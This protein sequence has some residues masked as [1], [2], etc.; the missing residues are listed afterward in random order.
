MDYKKS[1]ILCVAALAIFAVQAKG[2]FLPT[3]KPAELLPKGEYRCPAVCSAQAPMP[4]AV[5]KQVL[6]EL[7]ALDPTVKA[8]FGKYLD[9]IA[10]AMRNTSC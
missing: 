3:W 5:R 1:V 4:L 10:G 6:A 7:A 2:F 8:T 9:R